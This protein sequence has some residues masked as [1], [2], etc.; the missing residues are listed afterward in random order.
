VL[1]DFVKKHSNQPQPRKVSAFRSIYQSLN[2][3]GDLRSLRVMPQISDLGLAQRG[4]SSQERITPIQSDYYRAPEV[5]L[6]AG[7]T[8][9]TDIWNFGL[10]VR[11]NLTCVAEI[12]MGNRSGSLWKRRPCF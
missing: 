10:L 4:H 2:D 11:S 7:W 3:F 12:L 5:I 9:S 6:G 1:L 8:Y